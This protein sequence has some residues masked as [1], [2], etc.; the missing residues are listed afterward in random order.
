MRTLNETSGLPA[1]VSTQS[2]TK[3]FLNSRVLFC[4]AACVDITIPSQ[5][6]R[7]PTWGREQARYRFDRGGLFNARAFL[8]GSNAHRDARIRAWIMPKQLMP[9]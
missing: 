3:H 4:S 2:T 8:N 5:C 7:I 9:K 6:G 1:T